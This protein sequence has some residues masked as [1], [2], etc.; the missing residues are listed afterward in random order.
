MRKI[1]Y[2]ALVAKYFSKGLTKS[3]LETIAEMLEPQVK[4]EKDVETAIKGVEPVL[5][6]L[7]SSNDSH[8]NEKSGLEKQ[9]EEMKK[10]LNPEKKDNEEKKDEPLTKEVVSSLIG[11]ALKP[12]SEKFQQ[13]EEATKAA[14]RQA[15]I[16]A[17]AKE[18]NIPEAVAKM[19]NVPQ[20]ADLDTY[21]KDA[22]QGFA[23]SGFSFAK[24]PESPEAQ[25]K[26]DAETIGKMISEGTKTIVESEKK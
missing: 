15:D 13:Q 3:Q 20:D 17:K 6:M 23:D 25:I 24:A 8:R 22:K 11:E 10:K 5:N 7:Q 18:Y 2:D 9:I 4:E 26:S 14:T 16:I 19:L 12:F 1:I 21:M